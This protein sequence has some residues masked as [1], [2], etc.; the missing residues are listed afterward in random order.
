MNKF[1]QL[2]QKKNTVT[3]NG[4]VS[5]ST[6]GNELTDQFGKAGSYRNR[7]I[8]E[9]FRDQA[10]LDG[11]VGHVWA[12]RFVLYLRLITRVVNFFGMF[13]TETVQRGQGAKDESIKRFLWYALNEP[14]LFKKYLPL[15]I[16]VGSF[17]DLSTMYLIIHVNK[18]VFDQ[19]LKN[20]L[21]EFFYEQI[22]NDNN[23]LALKYMPLVKSTK[24]VKR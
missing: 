2:A 11:S 3:E 12:L 23:G 6:T 9:V 13:K 19:R 7:P 14:D 22:V 24:S 1:I 17:K 10:K 20:E 5:N 4:A 15:F 16:S 18:T 8:S 21:V